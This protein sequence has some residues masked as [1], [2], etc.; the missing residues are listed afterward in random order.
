VSIGLARLRSEP[1]LIRRAAADKGEDAAVVDAALALD[2]RRRTLLAQ[3]D[4]L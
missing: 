2:E 3:G 1:D 4:A